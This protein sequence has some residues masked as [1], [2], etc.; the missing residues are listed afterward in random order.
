MCQ[1]QYVSK[2]MMKATDL[3]AIYIIIIT[4]KIRQYSNIYGYKDYSCNLSR[5]VSENIK[6][7]KFRIGNVWYPIVN[8][9]T[10]HITV[11]TSSVNLMFKWWFKNILLCK[12]VCKNLAYSLCY[13]LEQWSV[14]SWI[15]FNA[16]QSTILFFMLLHFY[17]GVS[18]TF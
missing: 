9:L 10:L 8:I 13:F 5:H 1:K 17:V 2:Q 14:F 4:Y 12:I 16:N 7:Q 15:L 6:S 18:T 11:K 3:T